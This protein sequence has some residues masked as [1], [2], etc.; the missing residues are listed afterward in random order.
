MSYTKPQQKLDTRTTKYIEEIELVNNGQAVP[1]QFRGIVVRASGAVAKDGTTRYAAYDKDGNEIGLLLKNGYVIVSDKYIENMKE[2]YGKYYNLLGITKVMRVDQEKTQERADRKGIYA[3]EK[4]PNKLNLPENEEAHTLE[5]NKK[6]AKKSNAKEKAKK[7]QPENKN[8]KTYTDNDLKSMKYTSFTRQDYVKTIVPADV[9]DIT[10]VKI[11]MGASGPQLIAKEIGCDEYVELPAYAKENYA[12][13]MDK[14]SNGKEIQDRGSE[15]QM[16]FKLIGGTETVLDIKQLPS[17]Q[18]EVND[19]SNRDID[20]D[21]DIEAIQVETNTYNTGKNHADTMKEEYKNKNYGPQEKSE[22]DNAIESY[23]T[24]VLDRD[25]LEKNK[26]S[27]SD[28]QINEYLSEIDEFVAESVK[29]EVDKYRKNNNGKNPTYNELETITKDVEM[30]D[31][32][33]TRQRK[34]TSTTDTDNEEND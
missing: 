20:G 9:Y 32:V 8:P 14:I 19:I 1:E 30:N 25:L 34:K 4:G 3:P 27:L 21:G 22:G 28:S 12:P 13:Q 29:I 18:I 7:Q 6:V 16:K 33:H 26:G 23:E 17:G 15:H 31:H 2:E 11:V 24:D 10:S 5:S